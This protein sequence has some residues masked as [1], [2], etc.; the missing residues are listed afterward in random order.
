MQKSRKEKVNT[1]KVDRIRWVLINSQEGRWTEF[2]STLKW[3]ITS[4]MKTH[5]PTSMA[6]S[7]FL[8]TPVHSSHLIQPGLLLAFKLTSSL[9]LTSHLTSFPPVTSALVGMGLSQTGFSIPPASP[10]MCPQVSSTGL[11]TAS[12]GFVQHTFCLVPNVRFL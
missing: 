6:S 11:S 12:H 10:T 4:Q 2:Y 5:L 3:S 7:C 9:K 8:L 1:K